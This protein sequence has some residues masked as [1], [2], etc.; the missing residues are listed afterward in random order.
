MDAI[1]AA[2]S[3]DA[4][5]QQLRCQGAWDLLSLPLL[6]QNF[7]RINWSK[8]GNL[9]IDGKQID[10]MD[11]AGAWLLTTWQNQLEQHG[12]NVAFRNFD[13]AHQKLLTLVSDKL[14][15]EKPLPTIQPLTWLPNMGKQV[16]DQLSQFRDYLAFIG[17]LTYESLRLLRQPTHMRWSA[18]AAVIYKTGFQALPI[19]ALL[20]FMIG[21]VITFQMGL[22]LRNYGANIYIV[23][24][25]GLSVLREFGPLLTAIMVAGRTGSAFTAQL[26]MMKIN[27][28]I[29][30]LNTMGVTPAEL[31]LLPRIIGL[32]IALPLLTIWSDI[33]GVIGGMVM[34]NNMLSI[35]WHDFM[36]RFPSV[37][38]LRALLIGLGKAP[39]FAL[40]IA[41]VGCF[42]GMKVEE[43]AD[44]VGRNTTRSVVLAI[45]FI[46]V[47]DALFSVI[48]SKLKL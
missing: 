6:Q 44:S 12:I 27:Q 25:L 32:T 28:E 31:L 10:K 21:V 22:Q 2:V 7:A 20:S 4:Q 9:T 30:A 14:K 37:I 41:S 46:I 3:Y 45:F 39:V 17:Q 43:K 29:D 26:G 38:P 36:Q 48:F 24:L 33:F 40:I 19:I 16:I 1:S 5:K 8:T 23:D 18:L 34:S 15:Q 42:Q 47:A 13:Q 35:S 11:S